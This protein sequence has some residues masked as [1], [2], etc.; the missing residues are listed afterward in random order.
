MA[1]AHRGGRRRRRLVGVTGAVVGI[2][3]VDLLTAVQATRAKET[4]SVPSVR[5]LTQK[6][7]HGADGH[8]DHSQTRAGGLRVLA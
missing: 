5:G 3:V 4:G 1:I 2:S 8:D 6:E 7:D